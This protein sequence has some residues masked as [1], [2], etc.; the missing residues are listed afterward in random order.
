MY[1]VIMYD[2]GIYRS[3]ELFELIEDVGGVVL[4]KNRSAQMLT[5]T[6]S[7]P[8]EDREV[9]EALCKDIGGQVKEV[10]L[11][12]T[13]IAV[14]GPTLGRHHMPHPIC[15]V[16]EYLRRL[17]AVTVVM[18]LARGRGKNTSQINLQETSIIDEYD[19][20][21]FMLGNFKPCVET[22]A[23]L[24]LS[25]INIPTVLMCGPK[26][27]GIE[28]TCD[29][30]VW[31]IGR[32]AARM[33]EPE[34]RKKLEEV[35]DRVDDV[36][37]EK[38]KALEE[39]PPFVHPSEIKALLENFEP[40]DMCLRPAPLVMH[41]DGLRAK[42]SY[43]EYHEQIENMEVYGRRLG[44]VC[45]ITPSKINDSSMLIRIKTRSQVAYEDSL[46]ARQ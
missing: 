23:D 42:I 6:M 13:E 16:A 21:V 31:G 46:K 14:V 39:D 36:L 25:K 15:D 4:L 37:D 7:I 12:G 3:D 38:K 5:V 24:L 18:G 41:L 17:G 8:S 32:K 27:E 10:P 9:V 35:G 28:D 11:A 20:C 40:I 45:V 26:P 30:I 19:A 43:D 29:A 33:R 2:G 1:E 34:D 22:K 44:D